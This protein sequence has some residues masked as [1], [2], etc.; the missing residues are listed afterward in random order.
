MRARTIGQIAALMLAHLGGGAPTAATPAMAAPQTGNEVNGV[1]DE[2][3]FDVLSDE[4]IDGLIG[5]RGGDP[6]VEAISH[7]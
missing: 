4:E 2:I 7:V 6:S 1:A 5:G 3:D